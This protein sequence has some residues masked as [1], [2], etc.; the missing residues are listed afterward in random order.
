MKKVNNLK[1]YF[2]LS[3]PFCKLYIYID[4]VHSIGFQTFLYRY[5]KLS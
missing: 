5:L 1:K 4:V 2:Y 3:Y